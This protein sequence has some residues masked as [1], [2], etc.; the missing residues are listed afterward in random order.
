MVQY[1]KESSYEIHTTVEE[2]VAHNLPC[3]ESNN[4]RSVFSRPLTLVEQ[5]VFVFLRDTSGGDRDPTS[6]LAE[7]LISSVDEGLQNHINV[8]A[9][10]RGYTDAL[11]CASYVNSTVDLWRLEA[12]AFVEWRDLVWL[13]SIQKMKDARQGNYAFESLEKFIFELPTINWPDE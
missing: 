9:R 11:H 5:E 10:T 7:V 1:L 4:E 13:S 8:T 6:V 2:L 12:N 3:L